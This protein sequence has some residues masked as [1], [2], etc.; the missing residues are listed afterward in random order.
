MTSHSARRL[1]SAVAVRNVKSPGRYS[2]GE[3][4]YLM[5]WPNGRKTWVQRLTID[6]R[7]TDLGL[8]P[9]PA[10]S[11]AQA[12]QKALDNRSLAKSGGNPLVVKQEEAMLSQLPT[13]EA[14]ARQHIAENLHSWRNAKHRAQWLSTLA[15]YAFPTLGPLRVN[16]ITRRHVIETLTRIWTTKSE[17]ARRV[18]QRI[19]AVMDRAVAMEYIDYNPA[20]DAI[21]AALARQR[22][23]RAHHPA[24]P[25]RD[26]P[27]ALQTVRESTASPSVKLAFQMLALTACRSGEVRGMTRDELD[28][29]EATWTIPGSRM[30]AGKPHRVPLSHEALAILDEAHGLSDGSGLV[31]PAP[32]S[33]GIISDMAFTQLLRRLGLDFV[34]HGLRSS[35][36]DWAAEQTG[37][38][39]AVVET[40]LAHTVG[41]AT[42]AAYFRSDL[43][44]LR[45]ALMDEWSRFLEGG[46]NL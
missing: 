37:S 17:T 30:K 13:F 26:L 40:A 15:T 45:R 8:G 38:P 31:F 32:R 2:A 3:T 11:L 5:V 22:R 1:D 41:N 28:L 34:P 16:E 39:H 9:Y 23:V 10:V 7:R 33:R 35:F 29:H 24:L 42:E 27:A 21:N 14:L 43:F 18:R 12:R 20:G 19:R 46:I 36:R 44:E 25:Y 4:L 6:G